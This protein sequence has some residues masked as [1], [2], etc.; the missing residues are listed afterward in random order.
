MVKM[1]LKPGFPRVCD[2]YGEL[3]VNRRQ[4]ADEVRMDVRLSRLFT[5]TEESPDDDV[6]TDILRDGN[7]IIDFEKWRSSEQL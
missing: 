3:T 6:I 2:H 5:S 4:K 7:R 1:N